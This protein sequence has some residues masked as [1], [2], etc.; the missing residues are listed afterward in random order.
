MSSV[1]VEADFEGD[2]GPVTILAPTL[3]VEVG[4]HHSAVVRLAPPAVPLLRL[5]RPGVP[6]KRTAHCQS[7]GGAIFYP[8]TLGWDWQP[9]RSVYSIVYTQYV[10]GE[11]LTKAELRGGRFAAPPRPRPGAT[12]PYPVP[13]PRVQALRQEAL[14]E[15]V[16]E[17]AFGQTAEAGRRR[18]HALRQRRRRVVAVGGPLLQPCHSRLEV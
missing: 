6:L 5:A 16:N 18:Q 10:M 14:Q 11:V 4:L 13:A 7:T 15:V 17:R 1:L 8:P 12:L 2:V 3:G 9:L